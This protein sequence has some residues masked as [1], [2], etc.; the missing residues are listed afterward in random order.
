MT[1]VASILL[2]RQKRDAL[3]AVKESL[4]RLKASWAELYDENLSLKAE[5]ESLREQLRRA[6]ASR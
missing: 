1:N 3:E 2:A 5:V 6:H 4:M